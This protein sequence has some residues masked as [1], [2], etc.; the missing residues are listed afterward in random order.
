MHAVAKK[1]RR[2]AALALAVAAAMALAA[3][4]ALQSRR[5]SARDRAHRAQ[6]VFIPDVPGAEEA[7][8]WLQRF[9]AEQRQ[10]G[11]V[12]RWPAAVALPSCEAPSAALDGHTLRRQQQQQ[13]QRRQQRQQQQRQQQQQHARHL[14][15]ATVGDNWGPDAD[16]NR[17]LD[18]EASATFDVVVIYY[19]SDPSWSC[20]QC[21]HTFYGQGPKWQLLLNVTYSP[22]WEAIVAGRD[23]RRTFVWLP[24]DDI[25]ASSC[26]ITRFLR[27]MEAHQLVLAQMSVCRTNGTEVVWDHM[28]QSCDH[29]L[30]YTTFVE[31]MAASMRLDF[32]QAVVRPTLTRSFTGWGLDTIWPYLLR[33]SK[34]QIAVVNAICMEHRGNAGVGKKKDSNS[35]IYE[36]ARLSS[37]FESPWAE[38]DAI[39]AEWR[40]DLNICSASWC[41]DLPLEPW[42]AKYVM[43]WHRAPLGDDPLLPLLEPCGVPSLMQL[44]MVADSCARVWMGGH[45]AAI[46]L[47]VVVS[48]ATAAYFL[49]SHLQR[50]WHSQSGSA[51]NAH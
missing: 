32:F 2:R 14:V 19:G 31:I 27:V 25:V 29:A 24:D 48:V 15:L 45:M 37:P 28:F 4:L 22:E 49:H 50:L 43:E 11:D 7:R 12:P 23:P 17:W 34:D 30:R 5:C 44:P 10:R 33:Y 40:F 9:H 13:Q 47:I 38:D 6:E 18:D 16:T 42:W 26:D 20:P 21:L 39:R 35:S 46:A 1:P 8:A 51:P 41:K 3:L 36:A